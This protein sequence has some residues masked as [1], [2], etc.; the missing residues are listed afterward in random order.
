MIITILVLAVVG[1]LVALYLLMCLT[2][3]DPNEFGV[4]VVLGKP[5][6][7]L[8]SGW[9]FAWWP[10]VKV[11]KITKKM[12]MFKF[13]VET[14]VTGRGKIDGYDKIVEPVEVDI[15]CTVYAQFDENEADHIIQYAPGYDATALGP[16][17]VPYAMD[18]VR[19]LA[20]RLPWRLINRERYKS[21]TWV[22]A[23]LIGGKYQG[24]N[25]DDRTK[26]IKFK[27]VTAMEEITANELENGKSPFVTLHLK[28]VSFVIEDLKFKEAV[29][30]SIVA[31][32]KARLDA[33][34][35]V[36]AAEASKTKKIKEGEGDATARG[37]MLDAIKQS[38][39][40]EAL[41]ALKE[42]GKGSS[43]FIFSLPKFLEE[44]LAK[45]GTGGKS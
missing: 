21:A 15:E 42:I 45:I 8:Q 29:S 41:S 2:I 26:D 20:G 38:P 10:F 19:A 18:T 24:I 33:Q 1:G 34:A 30:T 23:R 31:P 6:D 9:Y 13:V 37:K 16:F 28:N 44:T 40:L 14:A 39:E 32:E 17:L 12:M 5:G 11:I 25:D 4:K 35:T 43:N 36:I 27:D 7:E 3:V 22:Q